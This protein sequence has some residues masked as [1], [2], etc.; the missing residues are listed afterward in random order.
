MR[1]VWTEQAI[2]DLAEI[3][4]YIEQDRP[5][6]A[7]RVAAHL[8]SSVEHLAEFP[9]LGKQGRR[10]GTRELVI[11]PYFIT[12]RLRP[13]RLEILSVWHGRRLRK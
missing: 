9:H 12:Y 6:A 1:I 7:G 4:A 2:S 10:P 11:P 3:E 5:Q 13:E 8:V